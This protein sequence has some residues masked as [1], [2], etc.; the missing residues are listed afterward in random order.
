MTR[1]LDELRATGNVAFACAAA[2]ITRAAAYDERENNEAFERAWRDAVA[3]A[4]RDLLTRL[5]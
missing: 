1:F 3:R 4:R 5:Q 2:D